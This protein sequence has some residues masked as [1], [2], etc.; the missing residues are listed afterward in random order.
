[1]KNN[2]LDQFY[3]NPK[4]TDY[5]VKKIHSM[6]NLE[7]YKIFEPLAGTGNFIDSLYKIA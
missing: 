5:L 1:M 4:V 7:Q 2:K 3:T 6:F